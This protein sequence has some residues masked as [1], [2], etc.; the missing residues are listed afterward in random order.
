MKY[1]IALFTLCIALSAEQPP[2][3]PIDSK[4]AEPPSVEQQKWYT[5]EIPLTVYHNKF[6]GYETADARGFWQPISTREEK[7][8]VDVIAVRIECVREEGLC[9]EADASMLLGVLEIEM[10]SYDI[11][12]WT[13]DNIVADDANECNRHTLTIDF[14]SNSVMVTDYPLKRAGGEAVLCQPLTDASSYALHGGQWQLFPPPPPPLQTQE[15]QASEQRNVESLDLGGVQLAL[16]ME[17]NS[18]SQ[19][20]REKQLHTMPV[21]SSPN[22]SSK[23]WIVCQSP[24]S[25]CDPQLGQIA[26]KDGRLSRV[27]KTWAEAKIA[28][29]AMAAL[30]G[31][32][33]DLE[34][35]GLTRCQL[36]SRETESP[37]VE[38]K[39]V[40][41]VCG[42]HMAVSMTQLHSAKTP[43]MVYIEQ[44]L[45]ASTEKL[46]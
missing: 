5:T 35:R 2:K 19:K 36:V 4:P 27:F 30:Y 39:T 46:F 18:V 31:A 10:S 43:F 24:E 44:E 1:V 14:K 7:Q 13:G 16:G 9:R 32:I 42:E 40:R 29:D 3:A 8:L 20:L 34:R 15:R 45:W 37:G 28:P 41:F 22:T 12:S 23:V 11:T 17:Q 21:P 26:F 25:E 38:T 33:R 6:P